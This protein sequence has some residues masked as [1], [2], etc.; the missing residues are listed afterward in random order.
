[1]MQAYKYKNLYSKLVQ[2]K[3]SEAFETESIDAETYKKILEAHASELYTPNFFIRIALGLLTVIAVLFSGVLVWF[4]SGAS[5]D[6]AF[7]ALFI[8]LSIACYTIL[9]LLINAK[10]YY[11]AGLDNVLMSCSIIFLIAAF[12]TEDYANNDLITSA[13]MILFCLWLCIRFTDGFMAMLAY[14]SL[15]IFIFLLCVKFGVA[16]KAI[17]PFILMIASAIVYMVANG[18]LKKER[19]LFYHFSC[20]A[21]QLLALILFYA[22]ANYFAVNEAGTQFFSAH[23]NMPAVLAMIYWILTFLIP[24]AYILYGLMKKDLLFIRTGIVLFIISIITIHYYYQL[25]PVEIDMLIGGLILIVISYLLIKYL[26]TPKHGFTFKN[27]NPNKKDLLNAEAL[28]I[29]QVFGKSNNKQKG[30]EFGGGSSG[31]G[32]ATGN[33]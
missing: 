14:V 24:V 28:I 6:Y 17:A 18:L 7:V 9:E 2:Q 19:L 22:S 10:Q 29:A 33:Y 11:N 20:K 30:F 16:G 1:M 27:I 32:G 4:I 26:R 12:L 3:A 15:Y 23:I 21:V 31:G 5:N 13:V 8:F 25:L